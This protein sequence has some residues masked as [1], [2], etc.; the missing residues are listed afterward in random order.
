MEKFRQHHKLN[1][2]ITIARIDEILIMQWFGCNCD[3]FWFNLNSIRSY[4]N[5]FV[6]REFKI[7]DNNPL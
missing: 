7:Y 4:K 5:F 6:I 2:Y 3:R 1:Y